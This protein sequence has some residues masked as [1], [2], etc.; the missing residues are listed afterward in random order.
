MLW[1]SFATSI[2]VLK[3][4]VV[5]KF[6][7]HHR[8]RP[9]DSNLA[10]D[11]FPGLIIRNFS[12]RLAPITQFVQLSKPDKL[13]Y[14][15]E[16]ST[17][18]PPNWK[19]AKLTFGPGDDFRRCRQIRDRK[20]EFIERDLGAVFGWVSNSCKPFY[21]AT[22]L[23]PSYLTRARV[24]GRGGKT[25]VPYSEFSISGSLVNL[26]SMPIT[27]SDAKINQFFAFW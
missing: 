16:F 7:V 18:R 13:V 14:F 19:M 8:T 20:A 27:A 2:V 22:F 25:G 6:H 10:E 1:T 23:P 24:R 4:L 3:T 5:R 12:G 17:N 9:K 21:P 26:R 11:G 15:L